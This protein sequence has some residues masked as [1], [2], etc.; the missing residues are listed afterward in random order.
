MKA[1][2]FNEQYFTVYNNILQ[3][4]FNNKKCHFVVWLYDVAITKLK[5]NIIYH[6]LRNKKYSNT[7]LNVFK[8]L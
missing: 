1:H 3:K 4:H 6:K 8:I 2:W 5:L 7:K